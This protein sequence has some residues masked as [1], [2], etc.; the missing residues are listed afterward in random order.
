MASLRIKYDVRPNN[1]GY[2]FDIWQT[3]TDDTGNLIESQSIL[4]IMGRTEAEAMARDI[5]GAEV[6]GPYSDDT[7]EG[8]LYFDPGTFRP[9]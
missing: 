7:P 8:E 1:S 5:R 6:I 3:I 9:W 4:S 2:T